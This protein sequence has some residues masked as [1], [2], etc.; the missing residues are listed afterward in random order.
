MKAVALVVVGLAYAWAS[1]LVIHE[2]TGKFD[3]LKGMLKSTGLKVIS[4]PTPKPLIA[5]GQLRYENLLIL[6]STIPCTY[7][8]SI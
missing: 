1:V 4:S 3:Q 7:I 8:E 5:D 2:E 6:S